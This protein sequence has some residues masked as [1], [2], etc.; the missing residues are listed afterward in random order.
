MDEPILIQ[1]LQQGE[2]QAFTQ[3]VSAYQH[4]VFNTVLGIL[5]NREDA[6]DVAQE[7]FVQVYQS[8]GQFKGESKLSTWLYRIA[9][10]KSLDWQRRKSR[11]KRFA[12]V[13]S[14]FGIV[15]TIRHDPPEFHHPGVAIENKEKAALLFK[16]MMALPEN[17]KV[18]FTLN[19]VEGLSYQEIAEVMQVTVASVE[20]FLHR[21][22][23]N[24]RKELAGM[25]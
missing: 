17:Q 12:V 1:Q 14:F 11:K 23:Q 7:V 22:K 21:A 16:A 9:V 8:I 15:D 10:T 19:K 5:Q 18:A 6:E 2:G 13:E 24:L 4:I 25:R 3:L 20:A